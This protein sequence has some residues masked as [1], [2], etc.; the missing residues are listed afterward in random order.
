MET[1]SVGA[2]IKTIRE[3]KNISKENLSE[4]SGL[5]IGQISELEEDNSPTVSAV[6]KVARALGVRVGT[7]LDDANYS[8][9]VVT[10]GT[11]IKPGTTHSGGAGKPHLSYFSLAKGKPNR[12][13]EPF[14]IE[15]EKGKESDISNL[16]SHEGE[17]FLFCLEGKVDLRYGDKEFQLEAGDSIYYDSI[18]EHYVTANTDKA[19]V[20]TVFY[21]PI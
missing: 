12:Y 18:V 13:M 7:F 8:S 21:M 2:K 9:P 10:K 20:L 6:I 15:I 4:L 19:K 16:S 11:T 3:L 14:I 1:K 5:T 17:E